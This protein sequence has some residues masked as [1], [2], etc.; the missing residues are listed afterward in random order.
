MWEPCIYLPFINIVLLTEILG[1]GKQPL[2]MTNIQ[3]MVCNW[4]SLRVIESLQNPTIVMCYRGVMPRLNP[5]IFLSFFKKSFR[6]N[7]DSYCPLLLVCDCICVSF[8][9]LNFFSC[10]EC[11]NSCYFCQVLTTLSCF[12]MYTGI[13][14]GMSLYC[15]SPR[16]CAVLEYPGQLSMVHCRVWRR[17]NLR[18]LHSLVHP[19]HPLLLCL[20]VQASV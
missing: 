6:W 14:N 4:L 2:S 19:L 10:S 18:S 17:H 1:S 15:C 8:V 7:L 13:L 11:L 9:F 3:P 20:L 12:V 16:D 5:P